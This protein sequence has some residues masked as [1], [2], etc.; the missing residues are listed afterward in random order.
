MNASELSPDFEKPIIVGRIESPDVTE[1]SGIAASL[2]QPNVFWTHNDSGDDAFIFAMS[3]SG[4]N[5]GTYRV[6]NARNSDWEDIASYKS[7][8]GT[9]YL[10]V[11]D[12]GNNKLERPELRMLEDRQFIERVRAQRVGGDRDAQLHRGFEREPRTRM[13]RR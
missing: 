11:G 9:C 12:I 2:C 10:Y 8:D 7:P 1:S 5:L 4:K 6:S 13:D 3:E